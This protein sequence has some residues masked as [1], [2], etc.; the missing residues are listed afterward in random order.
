MSRH[1]RFRVRFWRSGLAS[2]GPVV[3]GEVVVPVPGTGWSRRRG[4]VRTRPP[5]PDRRA[6]DVTGGAAQ[7]DPTQRGRASPGGGTSPVEPCCTKGIL[8]AIQAILAGGT[9]LPYTRAGTSVG[10]GPCGCRPGGGGAIQSPS[11]ST[12]S[13]AC[14]DDS[15]TLLQ[16]FAARHQGICGDGGGWLL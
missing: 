4:K 9:G 8:A 7:H 16:S 12:P 2:A 14:G 1:S 11:A 6:A 3:A 5:R 13:V 15:C 10:S